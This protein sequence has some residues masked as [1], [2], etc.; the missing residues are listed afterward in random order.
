MRVFTAFRALLS[1]GVPSSAFLIDLV[2]VLVLVRFRAFE[3]T[4]IEDE[5]DNDNEHEHEHETRLNYLSSR[6]R[7]IK[8]Q[9]VPR[10]PSLFCN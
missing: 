3:A 5:D 7:G 1:A 10:C 8:D 4:P 9:A 6:R 2:P